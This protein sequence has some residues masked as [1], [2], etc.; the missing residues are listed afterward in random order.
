M[1]LTWILIILTTV[2]TFL[3]YLLSFREKLGTVCFFASSVLRIAAAFAILLTTGD[4]TAV[5][6]LLLISFLPGLIAQC[7]HFPRSCD[8][9]TENKEERA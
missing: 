9:G 5:L 3:F 1:T 4:L 7:F 8:A 6:L 2:L